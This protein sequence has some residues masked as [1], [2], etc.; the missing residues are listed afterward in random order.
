PRGTAGGRE[1]SVLPAPG[2]DGIP[3]GPSPS[4]S[5][6]AS[7]DAGLCSPG[8]S[9]GTRG[10]SPVCTLRWRSRADLHKK[11][12]PHSVHSKGRSPVWKRRCWMRWEL[13]VKLFP[14]SGFSPVWTRWCRVRAELTLKLFPQSLHS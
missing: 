10:L 5:P 6:S 3:A 11:L 9:R 4:P 8:M 1:A 7:S 2:C 13:T 12:F 14:H